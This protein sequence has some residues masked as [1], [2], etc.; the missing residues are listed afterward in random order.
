M[1]VILM[2]MQMLNVVSV[3]CDGSG[4]CDSD[5]DGV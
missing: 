4:E 3:V 2:V 5:G 1:V